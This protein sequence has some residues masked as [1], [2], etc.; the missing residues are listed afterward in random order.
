MLIL[1]ALGPVPVSTNYSPL[2]WAMAAACMNCEAAGVLVWP[3]SGS[4]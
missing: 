2:A 1:A 4:V 3:A